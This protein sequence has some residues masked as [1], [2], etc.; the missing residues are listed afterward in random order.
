MARPMHYLKKV[1]DTAVGSDDIDY[2]IL[3]QMPHQTLEVLLDIY[4]EIWTN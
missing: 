4:N 3:K 2:Q 1:H